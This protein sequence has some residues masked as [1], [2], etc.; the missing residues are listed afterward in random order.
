MTDTLIIQDN[1]AHAPPARGPHAARVFKNKSLGNRGRRECRALAAPAAS[2]A[3]VESTR[4][5]HHR[6][7]ETSGIPCATVLT[8]YFVIS[9]V[10]G[11]S[12]HH[13]RRNAKHCRELTSASRC[14]DH[15]AWPSAKHALVSRACRVHRTPH[16]TFVTTAKRPSFRAR[17]GRISGFDLPDD[18][19]QMPA[20]QWHDGQITPKAQDTTTLAP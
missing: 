15:T 6:H 13:P 12:C 19:R 5:S 8:A 7:A 2:R 11:L 14:Q 17:G 4:V 20:A 10:I 9:L 1:F 18:A 16:P 3:K